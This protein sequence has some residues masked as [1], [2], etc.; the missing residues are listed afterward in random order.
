MTTLIYALQLLLSISI[1]I[2]A[3]NCT[4]TTH[5]VYNNNNHY[6]LHVYD[7]AGSNQPLGLLNS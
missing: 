7:F 1:V 6:T 2:S 3:A 4:C 5:V